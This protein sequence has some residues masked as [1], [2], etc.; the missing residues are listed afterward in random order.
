[1]HPSSTFVLLTDGRRTYNMEL[2]QENEIFMIG[3][4]TL[5]RPR[6]EE[7]NTINQLR[8]SF[9]LLHLLTKKQRKGYAKLHCV[10]IYLATGR[11][12]TRDQRRF[13]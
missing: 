13:I 2:V 3:S 8:L 10:A 9:G 7:L 12:A 1:M 11:R 4:V 5:R 6:Y